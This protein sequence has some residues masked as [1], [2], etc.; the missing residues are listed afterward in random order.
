[1]VAPLLR[2]GFIGFA[3]ERY[4]VDL[5]KTRSQSLRW[6]PWTYLEAD[7]LWVNGTHA[8]PARNHLVRVPSADP[9]KP[10]VLLNLQ[11]MG[12]PMA[13]TLPLGNA[14]VSPPFTFDPHSAPSVAEV[15]VTFE[16]LLRPLATQLAVA[17]EIV[18]RRHSLT[19]TVYHIVRNGVLVAIIDSH[20]DVGLA[21]DLAASELQEAVWSSRPE[22]ASA[23]PPH[24][25]RISFAEMM[26]QYAL[27]NEDDLLPAKYRQRTIYFRKAPAVQRR[28]LKDAHLAVLSTLSA[29]PLTFAQLQA[30]IGFAERQLTQAL[31]ALYFAGSITTEERLA[32]AQRLQAAR[33]RAKEAEAAPFASS[34]S[35]SEF[36]SVP[37]VPGLPPGGDTP[38][39]DTVPTPLGPH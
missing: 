36:G 19:S 7:A 11:E 12:R 21:P 32:D 34:M 10:A 33:R 6:Q 3:D 24:F 1:M 39:G 8:Q 29:Q 27:R 16:T 9:Q 18:A 37:P 2:M 15:L 13:F 14:A 4:L 25:R 38:I 17:G 28:S 20:R 30:Q 31:M 35:F 22:S 5:L 26:W 23:M